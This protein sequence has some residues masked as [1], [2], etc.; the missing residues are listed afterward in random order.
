MTNERKEFINK[1]IKEIISTPYDHCTLYN[2]LGNG[3]SNCQLTDSVHN[4]F[5]PWYVNI[6]TLQSVADSKDNYYNSSINEILTYISDTYPE[7]FV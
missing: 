3:C 7:A 2:I 6:L 5:N 4:C 1:Y